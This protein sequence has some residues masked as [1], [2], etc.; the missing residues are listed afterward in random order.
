MTPNNAA[1]IYRPSIIYYFKAFVI[2]PKYCSSIIMKFN[3]L[4]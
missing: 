1:N 2:E 3:D 4:Y